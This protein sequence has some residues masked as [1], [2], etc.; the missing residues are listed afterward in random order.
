MPKT[1]VMQC[2]QIFNFLHCFVSLIY[3]A[4]FTDHSKYKCKYSEYLQTNRREH[5][6]K[7]YNKSRITFNCDYCDEKFKEGQTRSSGRGRPPKRHGKPKNQTKDSRKMKKQSEKA[8][9]KKTISSYRSEGQRTVIILNFCFNPDIFFL[10][11]LQI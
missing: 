10:I 2:A 6:Q 9:S 5:W 7:Q 1:K 11:R 4:S 8:S 3:E